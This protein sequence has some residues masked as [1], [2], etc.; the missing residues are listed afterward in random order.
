MAA[1]SPTMPNTASLERIESGLHAPPVES[2]T[3]VG[4]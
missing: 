1:E 3:A 2:K 4:A